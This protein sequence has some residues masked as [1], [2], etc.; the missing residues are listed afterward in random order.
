MFCSIAILLNYLNITKAL[1]KFTIWIHLYV[2]NAKH[3]PLKESQ[4][5]NNVPIQLL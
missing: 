4:Q 5:D 2:E 1:F 3:D